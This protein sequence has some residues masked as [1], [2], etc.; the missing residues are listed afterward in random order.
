MQKNVAMAV[1]NVAFARIWGFLADRYGNKPVLVLLAIGLALTPTTWM[2]TSPSSAHNAS[3]LI[4]GHVF[5]G[6]VWGGVG[7]VQ[8]NLLL[9]T[10]KAEDRASYLGLAQALMAGVGGISPLLGA[11]LFHNLASGGMNV[12]FAYKIVFGGCMLLR[13]ISVIPLLRVREEGATDLGS[14]LRQIKNIS[15]SGY[16]ALG[17]LSSPDID[18]RE[19]GMEGVASKKFGIATEELVNALHDPTPRVRRKAAQSLSRLGDHSSA[20]ALIH[21]LQDHP[22]LVEDETIDALGSI[23]NPAA[24]PI[25]RDYLHSPRPQIRRAAAKAIGEIGGPDASQALLDVLAADSDP[26]LRR[27]ALQGLRLNDSG[28]AEAALAKSVLDPH[29]SVR[30][31][32]AE[33]ISELKV[34]QA[35]PQ[36]RSSLAAHLDE[37]GSEVAYA[38][39]CVGNMS[40][41][42]Q[43]LEVAASC[44]SVITRRRCLLGVAALMDVERETYQLMLLSGMSRDSALLDKIKSNLKSSP[45]LKNALE[46][47]SVG[48]EQKAIEVL[49]EDVSVPEIKLLNEPY[50]HEA[51]LIAALRYV[52]VHS[53]GG[54]AEALS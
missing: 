47:Y 54:E 13:L 44:I 46:A 9:A 4:I 41:T 3:I 33:A 51:F 38:L 24:V 45:A 19:E 2:L 49:A 16:L 26:D 28:G 25:L 43:I 15:P 30:I 18:R 14:T 39:G 35:A 53:L 8:F 34:A 50:V 17:K 7:I 40:D 6:F 1:G 27:A 31:A 10:A 37:A 32:A 12:V 5:I 42:P 11:T 52:K 36:L 48:N 20:E 23:G 21:M 22:D 29:P